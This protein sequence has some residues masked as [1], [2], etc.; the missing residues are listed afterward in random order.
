MFMKK[1]VVNQQKVLLIIRDGWGYSPEIEYNMIAQANTPYTDYLEKTY[2][3]TLLEASGEEAGLPDGYFGNSEVGHM[4]IGAGRVLEQSLLRINNSINDG[5]FFENNEFLKAINFVKK[6]GS[7]LHLMGLLQK[8]GV[9]SHFNHI[10]ALLELAK[11]QGLKKEDVIIHVITDGRD[12]E[13]QYAVN[14]ILDLENEMQRIDIGRIVTLAGRYFAMDRDNHW[15]RVEK[16]YKIICPSSLIQRSDSS[17]KTFS[18]PKKYLKEKYEDVEFSDEFLEPIACEN[19]D[20]MKENDSI[21]DFSFRKDRE[22]QIA[23]VFCED[24]FSKFKIF[25]KNIYFVSMTKYYE[26]GLTHVAYPD[27]EVV[28][29]LGKI[30]EENNKTQLRISETE[31]YA[32]VTFFF[33]GGKDYNFTGEKKIL[34]PSPD[35]ATFNMKP[36]MASE[37][38]TEKL[39]FEIESNSQDFILCNFPNADM[40]GH[41]GKHEAIKRGVEAV[42][43]SLEKIVPIALEKGYVVMLAADHGN[44]EYKYGKHST[45]HTNNLIPFTLISDDHRYIKLINDGGLK[46]I[47]ATI[48]KVM[49]IEKEDIHE[50]ALF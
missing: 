28:S 15:D 8:E 49:N 3:T 7:K 40:V 9:H 27:V 31:K 24:D 19:Y 45:S 38:I 11:N 33:D 48:F 5:S 47:L 39:I 21:I 16:Y 29:I 17:R 4:T 46:N 22:R 42:D 34:V 35:V 20:G 43:K 1:E 26:G 23:K 18:D 50:K 44:A 36:E 41:S 2:P 32:H 12:R 13:E 6:H 10:V 25:H 30:L 14:Y 37:E